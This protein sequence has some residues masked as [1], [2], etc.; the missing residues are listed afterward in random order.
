MHFPHFLALFSCCLSQWPFPVPLL[1]FPFSLFPFPFS[2]ILAL[3]PG[4]D[5]CGLALGD[6]ARVV[7]RAVV[8][9]ARLAEVVREWAGRFAVTRVIVGDRT[10]AAEVRRLLEQALPQVPVSLV[11]E[12]GSTLL[13]RR[14][15][16]RDHP[17]RGWRRLVPLSL[18]VPPEPYDD[19]AAEV[20]LGR[21]AG[22]PAAP[23]G[24][25]G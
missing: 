17:P 2:L 25:G 22:Q 16:F 24:S 9:R 19:Y 10:G 6:G 14:L 8:P 7:A 21:F 3:D 4:R 23:E 15:Y 13:A 20:L 1:L 11:P 5:K 18:Q 12:E